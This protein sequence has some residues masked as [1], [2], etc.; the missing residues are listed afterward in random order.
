M[1]MRFACKGVVGL[2]VVL[3]A[4]QVNAAPLLEIQCWSDAPGDTPMAWNPSGV[5][6]SGDTWS[7]DGSLV[8]PDG[9]WELSWNIVAEA[10][11]FISAG[12]SLINSGN[13]TLTYNLITTLPVSPAVVPSSLMGG[14]TG[15]SVTD[16]DFSGS[17]T[18]AT[19]VG[20]PF[21]AGLIDGV[22]VLPIYASGSWSVTTMGGTVN[23]P[24]MDVGLPGPTIAGP[25][26]NTDIGIHHVVTL[27]PG[28]RVA[29]TS[30]FIV[31]PEPAT[32]ALLAVGGLFVARRR[33]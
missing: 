17:A 28:D 25:A 19:A 33:R 29:F 11:P 4:A 13:T 8:D 23:I 27:S 14:S 5:A 7:Y 18:A 32:L 1:A 24:A 6:G 31:V 21:F 22:S 15:G 9:H 20:S 30:A 12:Y 2:I 10:D 26:V 3:I 16:A